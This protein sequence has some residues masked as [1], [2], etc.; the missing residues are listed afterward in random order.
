MIVSSCKFQGNISLLV[1]LPSSHG[2][3]AYS[4]PQKRERAEMRITN[5]CRVTT[6]ASQLLANFPPVFGNS[7]RSLNEIT[8]PSFYLISKVVNSWPRE[9]EEVATIIH[10]E[11]SDQSQFRRTAPFQLQKIWKTSF[12]VELL[13]AGVRISKIVAICWCVQK[14]CLF[15]IK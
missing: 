13:A 15:L 1:R 5:V 8:L 11:C 14:L 9:A 12:C 4:P 7:T 10:D 3:L 6:G 2:F